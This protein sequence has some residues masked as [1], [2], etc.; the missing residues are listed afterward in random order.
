[1]SEAFYNDMEETGAELLE[2]FGFSA[3]L[4]TL[5]DDNYDPVE[6]TLDANRAYSFSDIKV[7]FISSNKFPNLDK[8]YREGLKT[9][10]FQLAFIRGD[11]TVKITDVIER[12]SK[13][14]EIVQVSAVKPG[15]VNVINIA[16][17]NSSPVL[18][19]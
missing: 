9:V 4:G 17:V 2:E 10:K 3:R 15:T 12:D 19:S 6:E 13:H 11:Q 1:M 16:V 8:Q 18:S 7:V 5:T 14:F